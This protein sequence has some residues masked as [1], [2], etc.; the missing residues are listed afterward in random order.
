MT[1]R[2]RLVSTL[3]AVAPVVVAACV[4]AAAA[5][6][7][8][9]R[10]ILS[11]GRPARW[12]LL[13][14]LLAFG[15][16]RAALAGS[17]WRVPWA[18]AFALFAFCGLALVSVGWSVNPHG[19]LVRAA[20]LGVVVVAVGALAGCVPSTPSLAWRLLDGV[21]AA[22]AVVAFA[23][24]VYW[25][26]SP[27]NAA[28]AATVEYPS[29]Y[30]GIGQNPNTAPLLLAI[31]MPLA[32][33]RA[34][35]A[36]SSAARASFVLLVLGFAASIAASGSRSGLLAAVGGLIVV[37]LLA[38]VRPRLKGAVVL[39]VVVGLAVSAW[40][41][42]IPKALPATSSTAPASVTSRNAEQVLP[43]SQEIGNPWWTHR[44]GRSKR[45]LFN[46]SVRLRAAEGTV[47]RAL[48]RPLLGY[49]FGAEQWAFVNRYFAFNSENPED[50]YLGLFLQLGLLGPIVFLVAV[51]LC[52]IPGLCAAL[53][54]TGFALAAS[55]AVAAGLAAAI[56]QSYFHGPG[57]IAF[58]AF[59]VSLLV[60]GV[61]GLA[62]G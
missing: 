4:L 5:G 18:A 3:D 26:V 15:L 59:W 31:A 11:A 55:G 39:L 48:A 16:V 34:L 28:I 42:T 21:L 37:A 9:Q 2:V 30:Q 6:S 47:H 51:A 52:F 12:V 23:G 20:G 17:A 49:G 44:S 36:R 61:S 50:G 22:A 19:T 54:D 27:H 7:S 8:M 1:S 38:P 45:S 43:L 13:A 35:R 46:T 25:L 41:S 29:R 62:R 58:V 14:L 32:L 60:A 24:F 33:S 40:A 57:G 53:R 10:D 56:S